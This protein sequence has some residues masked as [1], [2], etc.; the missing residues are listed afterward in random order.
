MDTQKLHD[1]ISAVCPIEGLSIGSFDEKKTWAVKF[2][3]MA[4]AQQRAAAQAVIDSF[5][6]SEAPPS[7]ETPPGALFKALYNIDSRLRV[8][9]SRPAITRAQFRTGLKNL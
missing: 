7:D 8:L 6:A 4:T 3:A 1:Q 5:D 2:D 9:E